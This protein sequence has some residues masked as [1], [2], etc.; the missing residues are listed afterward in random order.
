MSEREGERTS[1]KLRIMQHQNGVGHH[2]AGVSELSTLG[3]EVGL[4]LEGHG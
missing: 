4:P 2:A 3:T 1:T